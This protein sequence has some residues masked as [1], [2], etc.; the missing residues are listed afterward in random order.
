MSNAIQP[1]HLLVIAVA[2]WLNRHQQ[3]VID[4]QS[5]RTVYP[6][7]N[8]KDSGFGLLTNSKI[9]LTVKAKVVPGELI[10]KP[11]RETDRALDSESALFKLSFSGDYYEFATQWKFTSPLP[12]LP[13]VIIIPIRK[14]IAWSDRACP[15]MSLSK[16]NEIVPH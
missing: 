6:R 13:V 16:P 15:K 4:Y 12:I 8:S 1:F 9:R 2:G 14:R 5:K 10:H 11:L 7:S 3:D